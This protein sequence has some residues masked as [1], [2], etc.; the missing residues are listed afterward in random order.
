MIRIFPGHLGGKERG[1]CIGEGPA[2]CSGFCITSF[3]AHPCSAGVPRCPIVTTLCDGGSQRV[4]GGRSPG[5]AHS[6]CVGGR[7][8]CRRR[9]VAVWRWRCSLAASILACPRCS[10][11]RGCIGHSAK[12][13]SLWRWSAYRCVRRHRRGSRIQRRWIQQ[14]Y[15]CSLLVV[16]VMDLHHAYGDISARRRQP[17]KIFSETNLF[18]PVMKADRERFRSIPF[19]SESPRASSQERSRHVSEPSLF[20]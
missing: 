4:F 17:G 14:R 12:P 10:A 18:L 11:R 5:D 3:R 19:R 6:H 1:F 13:C 9:P 7:Y 20:P 2:V 15:L 8:S 16:T